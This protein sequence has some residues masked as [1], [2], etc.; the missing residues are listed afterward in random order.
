MREAYFLRSMY[1]SESSV[2]VCFRAMLFHCRG[3]TPLGLGLAFPTCSLI[4]KTLR[5]QDVQQTREVL[6]YF[7]EVS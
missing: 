4:L 2:A 6:V 7:I 3:T 1:T 5:I